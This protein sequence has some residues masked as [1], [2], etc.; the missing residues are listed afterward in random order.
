DAATASTVILSCVFLVLFQSLSF[1]PWITF[2]EPLPVISP[3]PS[4]LVAR[5]P[6]PRLR[7]SVS[8]RGAQSAPP[9]QPLDRACHLAAG[10]DP[11]RSASHRARAPVL[12]AAACPHSG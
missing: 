12:S 6:F 1:S 11:R 4:L 5:P 8:A 10:A 9:L 7:Q 2:P 3:L